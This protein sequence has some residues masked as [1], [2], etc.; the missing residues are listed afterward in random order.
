M[1]Q[2]SVERAAQRALKQAK[3]SERA[4]EL[5]PVQP[6]QGKMDYPKGEEFDVDEV[7]SFLKDLRD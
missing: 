1:E 6:E 3:A 7:G 2:S 5:M 4:V